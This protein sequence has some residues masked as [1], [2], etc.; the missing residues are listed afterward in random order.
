MD[1]L[2]DS[3]IN[4][5]SEKLK[6]KVLVGWTNNPIGEIKN[7]LPIIVDKNISLYPV[8]GDKTEEPTKPAEPDEPT[9]PAEP[10]PTPE[11]PTVPVFPDYPSVPY[12]PRPNKP[13]TPTKDIVKDT[14]KPAETTKPTETVKPVE[15][16]KDYGIVETAP[17]IATTF[18]DL[19]ENEKAGSIMNMVARGV[20]KGMDNGKFEG[21]LPITRAMVAT[22]LKRLSID[23]TIN[24]VQNF[25]DVKDKDWYAE[26]VKWAQSQGLIKGYEDGTFKANN[27][28]TRQELAII[29]ERFLKI[30]GITMDEVRDLSYKDIDTLPAWSRDA[31]VAMAKIGLIE[32]QTAEMYNPTSEFTR[33]ELAVM[34]E[35]IIEWVEKHQ[36]D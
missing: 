1:D 9:K 5:L 19:P 29:I 36:R 18:A 11:E 31:I 17:T 3:D 21:E 15:E 16:K 14:T 25:K 34:L 27:L 12:R 13:V 28:V 7:E 32:G 30:C 6:G 26:A 33:E 20:L 35:K 24:N 8:F 10:T 4:I 2:K 22:V 23:Q